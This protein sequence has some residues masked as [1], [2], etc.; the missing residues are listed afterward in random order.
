MHYLDHTSRFRRPRLSQ[1]AF[2]SLFALWR[3]QNIRLERRIDGIQSYAGQSWKLAHWW[4]IY[5]SSVAGQ[6]YALLVPLVL[7]VL[8]RLVPIFLVFR[9]RRDLR[10]EGL[11]G[12]Y[13]HAEEGWKLGH[14]GRGI[15][16]LLTIPTS[17]SPSRVQTPFNCYCHISRVLET[18]RPP[19]G[20]IGAAK[21]GQYQDHHRLRSLLQVPKTPMFAHK[22]WWLSPR[23]IGWSEQN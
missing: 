7:T 17:Q 9:K 6:S 10:L 13:I 22:D 8:A 11:E 23:D 21:E 2:A 15:K 1:R 18:L 3:H 12:D 19:I 14:T 5:Q 20:K 4:R 16:E